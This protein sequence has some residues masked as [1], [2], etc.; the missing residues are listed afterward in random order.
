MAGHILWLKDVVSL[1][2]IGIMGMEDISKS[3]DR[4][5]ILGIVYD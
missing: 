4:E 5:I 3:Q 2:A 1:R